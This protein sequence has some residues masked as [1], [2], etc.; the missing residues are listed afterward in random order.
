MVREKDELLKIVID[1]EEHTNIE[2]DDNDMTLAIEGLNYY[3]DK[4]E[5]NLG[6][7]HHKMVEIEEIINKLEEKL[8]R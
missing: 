2:D 5:S 6:Y 3:V 7:I 8:R 1:I 4:I